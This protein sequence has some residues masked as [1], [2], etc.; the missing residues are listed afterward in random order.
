MES[1]GRE[2]GKE[3]GKQPAGG[4]KRRQS[5]KKM[6]NRGNELNDLLK[7]HHLAFFGAKN[8]LKTNSILSAKNAKNREQG[9]GN[10]TQ[11]TENR[12]RR[13]NER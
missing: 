5:A 8:E 9:T 13:A 10:S 2:R 6:L 4:A 1:A 11:G 12:E 7:T 3:I